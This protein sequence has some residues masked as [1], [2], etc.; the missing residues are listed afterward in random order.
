MTM[1]FT[2][3]ILVKLNVASRVGAVRGKDRQMLPVPSVDGARPIDVQLQTA[4]VGL[5]PESHADLHAAGCLRGRRP[6]EEVRQHVAAVPTIVHVVEQVV[7][8]REQFHVV[9]GGL[10][11]VAVKVATTAVAATTAAAGAALLTDGASAAATTGEAAATREAAVTATPTGPE[12][13]LLLHAHADGPRRLATR[14]VARHADGSLVVDTVLV[15]VEAGRDGVGRT[16]LRVDVAVGANPPPERQ[17]HL[18]LNAVPDVL[19]RGAPL[20]VWIQAVHRQRRR[21]VRVILCLAERVIASEEDGLRG[22]AIV[23]REREAIAVRFSG[24]VVLRQ[25]ANRR[26][27]A[28]PRNDVLAAL[29]HAGD[30]RHRLIQI[31][32][33]HLI[34]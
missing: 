16:R 3:V 11:R 6:E 7:G 10:V 20:G 22:H 33:T 4:C 21:A 5:E 28:D 2:P 19:P 8:R 1:T 12:T 27:R 25:V 15:R 9:A 30:R 31:D 34:P 18:R 17:V 24:G 29:V 32:R 23:R 13:E 26:I 14:R